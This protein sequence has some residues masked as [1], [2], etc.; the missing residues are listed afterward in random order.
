VVDVAV[1]HAEILKFA[2]DES[3]AGDFLNLGITVI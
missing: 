1:S 3:L 2:M